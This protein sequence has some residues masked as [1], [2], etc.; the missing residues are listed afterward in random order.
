MSKKPDSI[1]TA[2]EVHMSH[3]VWGMPVIAF[4]GDF[5]KVHPWIKVSVTHWFSTLDEAVNHIYKFYL[6]SFRR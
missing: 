5:E 1:G 6:P 2:I 3:D 4:G